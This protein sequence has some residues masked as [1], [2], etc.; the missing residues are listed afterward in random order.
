MRNLCS[1]LNSGFDPSGST[2]P[3]RPKRFGQVDHKF[4]AMFFQFGL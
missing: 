4:R 2:R 3:I 1:A